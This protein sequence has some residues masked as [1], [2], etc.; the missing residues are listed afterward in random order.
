MKGSAL[1]TLIHRGLRPGLGLSLSLYLGVEVAL[2]P[3]PPLI[4][5]GDH[6]GQHVPRVTAQLARAQSA[7]GTILVRMKEK[8]VSL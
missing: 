6:A 4:T 2:Q 1:F 3:R 8:P 5:A 7:W